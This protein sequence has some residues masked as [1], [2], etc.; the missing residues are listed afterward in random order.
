MFRKDA[1]V[2]AAAILALARGFGAN[3]AIFT[4]VNAVL[5]LTESFFLTLFGATVGISMALFVVPGVLRFV[6][7]IFPVCLKS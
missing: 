2:T 5:M 4:V 6:T 3:S 1:G 7:A